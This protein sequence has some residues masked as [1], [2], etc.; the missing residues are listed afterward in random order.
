MKEIRGFTKKW[1]LTKYLPRKHVQ[2]KNVHKEQEELTYWYWTMS[3]KRIG[4]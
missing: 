2:G 4:S 3:Y 1:E